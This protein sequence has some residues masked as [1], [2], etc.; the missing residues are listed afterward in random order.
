HL[1]GAPFSPR[2]TGGRAGAPFPL[3]SRAYLIF[4]FTAALILNII[5]TLTRIPNLEI[6][7]AKETNR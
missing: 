3:T 2:L 4:L 5:E 7:E 1:P 6:I